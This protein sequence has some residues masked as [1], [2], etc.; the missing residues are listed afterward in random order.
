MPEMTWGEMQQE[1]ASQGFEK[2]PPGTYNASVETSEI[3][4]S[5]GGSFLLHLSPCHFRH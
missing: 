5:L 4:E 1:A 2:L 3:V